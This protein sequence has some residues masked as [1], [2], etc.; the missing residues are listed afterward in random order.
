MDPRPITSLTRSEIEVL[1]LLEARLSISEIAAILDVSPGAVERYTSRI[2]RK[3]GIS[4]ERSGIAPEG[5]SSGQ[6]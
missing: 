4:T 1:R 6:S 5:E 2:Y 3:L